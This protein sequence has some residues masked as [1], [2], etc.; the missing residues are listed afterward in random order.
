MA[1]GIP[2][3]HLR[4]DVS[5]GLVESSSAGSAMV[6]MHRCS[7]GCQRCPLPQWGLRHL[8]PWA[9]GLSFHMCQTHLYPELFPV[10][11]STGFLFQSKCWDFTSSVQTCGS[12]SSHCCL[13]SC[14]WC[15]SNQMLPGTRAA[16]SSGAALLSRCQA[17]SLRS[18]PPSWVNQGCKEQIDTTC[19]CIFQRCCH[20]A[21]CTQS[22]ITLSLL[23]DLSV[24]SL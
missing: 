4:R 21:P 8:H 3:T 9:Q 13:P 16:A 2:C 20:S 18:F 10:A 17:M 1:V 22:S 7:K 11:I 24:A 23:P 19:M 14:W 6:W 12:T 15:P 5:F